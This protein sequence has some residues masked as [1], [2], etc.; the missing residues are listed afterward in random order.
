MNDIGGKN[1]GR[2]SCL[3]G[4]PLQ[5]SEMGHR[6]TPEADAQGPRHAL[7]FQPEAE[8][9]PMSSVDTTELTGGRRVQRDYGTLTMGAVFLGCPPGFR[10]GYGDLP[11]RS[12]ETNRSIE[13][14]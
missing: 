10:D 6:V 1:L 7:P 4:F 13:V 8:I 2:Q 12:D 11:D 5:L 14:D 9:V 3:A